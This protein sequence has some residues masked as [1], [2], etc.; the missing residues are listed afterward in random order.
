[1]KRTYFI[2]NKYV[3]MKISRDVYELLSTAGYFSVGWKVK[4]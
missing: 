3:E 4:K 1:M 2:K